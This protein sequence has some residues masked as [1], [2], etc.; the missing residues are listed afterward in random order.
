MVRD[1]EDA[2]RMRSESRYA[3]D[4]PWAA[5]PLPDILIYMSDAAGTG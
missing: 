5:A 4:D 1:S 3:L 2:D